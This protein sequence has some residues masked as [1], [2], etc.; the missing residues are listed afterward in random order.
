MSKRQTVHGSW[1]TAHGRQRTVHG[2]GLSPFLILCSLF[3]IHCLLFIAPAQ[4]QYY[5]TGTEPATIQWRQIKTG[6]FT[7]IY[8]QGVDTLAQRYAWLFD[9][10]YRHIAE[11]L[12]TG[13]SHTPVVLH[14]YN[15]NSNGVVVWAPK[16]ME[17][18]TTP[19]TSGYAQMWD[20]QLVA[21]ETR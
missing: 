2:A 12:R 17:L 4:A 20:R 9:R 6:K 18:I 21:H 13:L 7:V 11:P 15:L 8:P 5:N 14:P 19:A 1:R 10:S 16:R 3:L